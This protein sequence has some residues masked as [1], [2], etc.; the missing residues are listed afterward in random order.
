MARVCHFTLTLILLLAASVRCETVEALELAQLKD[1]VE[2]LKNIIEVCPVCGTCSTKPTSGPTA[3]GSE[4]TPEPSTTTTHSTQPYTAEPTTEPAEPTP[5]PTTNPTSSTTTLTPTTTRCGVASCTLEVWATAA[6]E[7]PCGSRILWVVANLGKSEEDACYQVAYEEFPVECGGCAP[8]YPTPRPTA[9]PLPTASPRPTSVTYKPGELTVS[10]NG[11]LLSTGL[12]SKVVARTGDRMPG[13]EIFHGAPDAGACFAHPSDGGWA[14]VSNSEVGGGAGGVGSIKFNAAGDVE[15][16]QRVLTGTSRNCGGGKT[17]WNTWLS[18][19][20]NGNGRVWEA[21]P[22]DPTK[23]RRTNL[24][25]VGS[26]YESVAYDARNELSFYTTDDK[27]DG[28]L[29]RFVPDDPSPSGIY[30]SGEYAYLILSN[31]GNGGSFSWTPSRG[32]AAGTVASTY[33]FAEGIDVSS[34][35]R[36]Y[37]VSKSFRRL[38]ILDLDAGKHPPRR[39]NNVGCSDSCS[40]AGTNPPRRSPARSTA[41]PTRSR[42]SSATRSSISAKTAGPTAVSTAGTARVDSSASWM[43]RPTTP[44]RPG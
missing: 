4:P 13:G 7:Y 18:C 25:D 17:P 14:Y 43:A 41:S 2:E 3:V 11:L 24:V 21:D 42:A 32:A 22:F 19:E 39:G 35:G 33:P 12:S 28:P 1:S 37:F 6:G 9:S 16:Y 20:E 26:N 10:E 31:G 34:D 27:A 15:S 23:G 44:R 36:L 30:G 8:A 40:I 29:T 38:Y 5:K